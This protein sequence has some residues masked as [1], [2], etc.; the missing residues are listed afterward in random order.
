MASR[1]KPR[2]APARETLARASEKSEQ[3]P[4]A[5]YLASYYL[6]TS[7]PEERGDIY[8]RDVRRRPEIDLAVAQ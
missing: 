1:F 2:S 5:I 4:R 8:L 3:D 7:K 6:I